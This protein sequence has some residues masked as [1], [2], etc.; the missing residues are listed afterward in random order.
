M[1][2]LY[3]GPMFRNLGIRN[4]YLL[5]FGF[6]VGVSIPVYVF[7]WKGPMIRQKSQFAQKLAHQ[8]E[9]YV[10][11]KNTAIKNER[12]ARDRIQETTEV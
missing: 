7:Y 3:T 12:A 4:S 11:N 9:Q 10:L 6:A 2:A 5:L 1:C 8:K